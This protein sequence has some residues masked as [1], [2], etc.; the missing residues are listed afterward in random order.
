MQDPASFKN[1][2]LLV[3]MGGAAGSVVR[4]GIIKAMESLGWNQ[5]P[6]ATLTVNVIG[7]LLVGFLASWLIKTSPESPIRYFL[8]TGYCGGFTTFSAF[9]LENAK[10]LSE[11]RIWEAFLY[12]SLSLIIGIGMVFV[13][14][15]VGR[16]E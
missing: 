8:I 1:L 7:C 2:M 15:W 6:W 5:W 9:G 13:G 11:G 12:T 3:A 16:M 10:M 4:F 14:M